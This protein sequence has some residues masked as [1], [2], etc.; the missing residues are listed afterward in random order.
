MGWGRSLV[1]LF[2]PVGLIGLCYVT[3]APVELPA[4]VG[5]A[6]ADL[7]RPL[8][9]PTAAYHLAAADTRATGSADWSTVEHYPF[10]L[11]G[12][13]SLDTLQRVLTE[14]VLPTARALSIGYFDRAPQRPITIVLMSSESAYS[15]ALSRLGHPGREEYA[16]LYSRRD[17]RIVLNL[18]TGEGT[19]AH[20]L[21]HAL[22]HVDCPH[23]PEWLDEGLASLHEESVFSDDGLRLIGLPNWR[24][25]ILAEA[26]ASRRAPTIESLVRTPFGRGQPA[27]DY[28]L[29]R[30]GCLFL[31]DRQLLGAYYRKCRTRLE[32]DPT[33]GRALLEIVGSREFGRLE[34]EFRDWFSSRTLAA[35]AESDG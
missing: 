10:L 35:A 31:Q 2:G 11:T 33:G 28:A 18:G 3:A 30:N 8:D 4:F 25:Q 20:E 34:Q 26:M 32:D 13:V 14:V 23:L 5:N 9:H 27:V 17:S 1:L 12:D 19:L 29:A 21:T 16:G 15:E 7:E 24:D 22:A 6:T